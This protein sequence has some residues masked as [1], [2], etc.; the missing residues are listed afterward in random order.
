MDVHCCFLNLTLIIIIIITIKYDSSSFN[1][2][3][4]K[5]TK[6][7]GDSKAPG[8]QNQYMENCHVSHQQ[9]LCRIVPLE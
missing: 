2:Q 7:H 3:F 5:S 8:N 9:A 1:N 6:G 4:K